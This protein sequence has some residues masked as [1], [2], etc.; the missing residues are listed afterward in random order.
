MKNDAKSNAISEFLS[1]MLNKAYLKVFIL[2]IRKLQSFS[3][4]KLLKSR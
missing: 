3:F 1:A 2:S 4:K